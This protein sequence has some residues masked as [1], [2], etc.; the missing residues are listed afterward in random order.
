M[1]FLSDQDFTDFSKLIYDASGIA[2]SE[3]NRPVLESRIK[4]RMRQIK[5]EKISDYEQKI[6]AD[7]KELATLLDNVTTNLTSFFRLE[8]HF[9]TLSTTIL[10]EIIAAK[11]KQ[12]RLHIKIWSA[13]SSTGEEAY[14]I[15]ITCLEVL[16]QEAGMWKIEIIGSDLSFQSLMVANAGVY[17]KERVETI[18]KPILNKYFHPIGDEFAVNDEVKRTCRFDYHNLMFDNGEREFDIIFCRNVIIYFDRAAQ[19]KVMRQFFNSLL[20]GGYLFI[21]HS[22]SLFGMN[23]S[24]QFFKVG[25][26]ILYRKPL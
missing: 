8:K 20:P 1:G 26:T 9:E 16:K 23:T 15:A 3:V 24:F 11:Q 2:F 21:G 19:E 13:G 4:E 7:R 18:P 17:H 14:S 12:R 22:E 25:N 6:K 5:V 10:P